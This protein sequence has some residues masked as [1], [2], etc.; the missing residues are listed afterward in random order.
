[1]FQTLTTS[2]GIKNIISLSAAYFN[3]L[4]SYN[5]AE[6]QL[7]RP[8]FLQMLV[9]LLSLLNDGKRFPGIP[10]C[11]LKQALANRYLLSLAFLRESMCVL[12]ED[13]ANLS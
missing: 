3:S 5:K 12:L 13:L 7:I 8:K 2:S 4:A 11:E 9:L 10:A 1:M 6:Q